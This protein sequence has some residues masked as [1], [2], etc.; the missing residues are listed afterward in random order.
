MVRIAQ[1]IE[2]ALREFARRR[3]CIMSVRY[4]PCTSINYR[5]LYWLPS[6]S[7]QNPADLR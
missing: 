2:D 6:S 3:P 7:M 5:A 1:G 4:R